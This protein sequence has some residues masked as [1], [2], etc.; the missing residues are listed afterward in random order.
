MISCGSVLNF[1]D[2]ALCSP[3]VRIFCDSGCFSSENPEKLCIISKLSQ[4]LHSLPVPHYLWN[5]EA[6]RSACGSLRTDNLPLRGNTY[7]TLTLCFLSFNQLLSHQNTLSFIPSEYFEFYIWFNVFKSFWW[8]ILPNL[9]LSI[10]KY[11]LSW[12][13]YY[14]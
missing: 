14:W 10:K 6:H 1:A 8:R 5:V 3:S 12:I 9:F 4:L 2:T 13:A 11:F 7:F